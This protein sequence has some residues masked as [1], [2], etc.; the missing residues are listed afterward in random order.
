MLLPNRRPLQNPCLLRCHSRRRRRSRFRV[1]PVLWRKVWGSYCQIREG[2]LKNDP[3]TSCPLL[4]KVPI[5]RLYLTDTCWGVLVQILYL[6]SMTPCS[7]TRTSLAGVL[8]TGLCWQFRDWCLGLCCP[9]EV[10][11]G[12]RG[13]EWPARLTRM[14]LTF[15]RNY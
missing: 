14:R 2:C 1:G 13:E 3:Y 7:G 10:H 11:M 5:E 12:S 6:G 15:R 9:P 4:G 8:L